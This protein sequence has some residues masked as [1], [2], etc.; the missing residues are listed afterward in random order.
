MQTYNLKFTGEELCDIRQ[1]LEHR[2]DSWRRTLAFLESGT[3]DPNDDGPIEDETDIE[4]ARKIAAGYDRV[5][6]KIS[7]V[8][9]DLETAEPSA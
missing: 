2:A 4:L 5:L 3:N 7:A 9:V 8:P 1:A 6:A